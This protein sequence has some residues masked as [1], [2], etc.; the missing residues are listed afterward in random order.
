MH[1]VLEQKVGLC[2]FE[3]AGV[4]DTGD[5]RMTEPPEQ[6]AFAEKTLFPGASDP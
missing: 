4:Q 6:L 1:N 2:T 3:Y 5:V